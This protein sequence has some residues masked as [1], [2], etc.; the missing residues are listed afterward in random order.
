MRYRGFISYSRTDRRIAGRIHRA[1]ERYRAPRGINTGHDNR[2]LGR[3]F[4]DDDELAGAEGLGA[5]LD[6]AIDDSE[7]LIVIASPSSARSQ[8]VNREVIRF[9]RRDSQRVLAFIVDGT[10]ESDS[11]ENQCFAPA[12]RYKLGPNETTTDEPDDPPLAPD[13]S[14]DGFSR[15]FTRLVAGVLDVP[16]DSLWRRERRRRLRR[17]GLACIAAVATVLGVAGYYSTTEEHG[18]VYTDLGRAEVSK[19]RPA[20]ESDA[21]I[22]FFTSTEKEYFWS[23]DAGH[24]GFDISIAVYAMNN[25]GGIL[26]RIEL[27]HLGE[28]DA[29]E[30]SERFGVFESMDEERIESVLHDFGYSEE[31]ERVSIPGAGI[32]YTLPP[33]MDENENF[34]EAL[35]YQFDEFRA[36]QVLGN[37]HT[38]PSNA[39]FTLDAGSSWSKSDVF[40]IHLGK[41]S[42]WSEGLPGGCILVGT[43]EDIDPYYPTTGG[44]YLTTDYG[45]SWNYVASVH[46]GWNSLKNIGGNRSN[47]KLIAVELGLPQKSD[48]I[49][50]AGLWLTRNGGDSWQ[51]A[52][53]RGTENNVSGMLVTDEEDLVAIVNGQLIRYA[54][55]EFLDRLL[56]RY[57]VVSTGYHPSDGE[58]E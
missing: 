3:F 33:D 19:L 41:A 11:E 25:Q 29:Y 17:L 42:I 20:S 52:G 13:L 55:R 34:M 38:P 10:P 45:K 35:R 51:S 7:N 8:W 21:E 6:G 22:A 4:K 48:E 1:L 53:Y 58:Q 5:A 43:P 56:Q 46:D 18:V 2:S 30:E 28:W 26:G 32:K 31:E 49:A 36:V 23:D 12:L 57:D 40:Y 9:K 24:E 44:L 27:I 37:D 54:K 16:F 14:E 47:P 50:Q 15:A 39:Y